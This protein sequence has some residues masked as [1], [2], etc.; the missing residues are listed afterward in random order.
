M[1]APGRRAR[2]P[3]RAAVLGLL[4]AAGLAAAGGCAPP[5]PAGPGA[6]G[7]RAA[8]QRLNAARPEDRMEAVRLLA[9]YSARERAAG[10]P[11]EAEQYA[12][13]VRQRFAEERD[14]RVRDAIVSVAGPLMAPGSPRTQ[15]FLRARLAEGRHAGSAAMALAVSGAAGAYGDIAPLTA[16]PLPEARWAG[17]M[18]LCLLGDPRGRPH[19]EGVWAEMAPGPDGRPPPGWPATV[20]GMA[21]A[22][23]R[24]ALEARLRAAF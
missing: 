2:P 19:A 15:A 23:A 17:A 9:G 5:P 4:A 8:L 6:A 7:D 14:G 18:A 3:P 22:E 16:H 1:S 20:R 21:P 24:S 13:L 11:R 12:A 10:R